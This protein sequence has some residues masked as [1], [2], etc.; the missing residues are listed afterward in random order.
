MNSLLKWI[1]QR[2]VRI[3]HEQPD[4]VLATTSSWISFQANFV[5]CTYKS[6]VHE[7]KSP[8]LYTRSS[9]RLRASFLRC[10]WMWAK[11]Q[12]RIVFDQKLRWCHRFC[13]LVESP[14]EDIESLELTRNDENLMNFANLG[15]WKPRGTRLVANVL[16]R[17][18]I[19]LQTT[20]VL[21]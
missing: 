20:K 3:L 6:V 16:L 19:V 7:T 10:S 1:I 8:F 14:V 9:L 11:L 5:N 12:Q 15:L 17:G 2:I 4:G 21:S 13:R 18:P